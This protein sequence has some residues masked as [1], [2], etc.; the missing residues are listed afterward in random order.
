MCLRIQC[1][2]LYGDRGGVRI[3]IGLIEGYGGSPFL[4]DKVNTIICGDL[5]TARY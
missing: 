4:A 3:I 1:V 5:E 2:G